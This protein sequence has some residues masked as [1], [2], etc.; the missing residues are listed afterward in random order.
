MDD[1]NKPTPILYYILYNSLD[2][3]DGRKRTAKQFCD[4]EQIRNKQGLKIIIGSRPK[5]ISA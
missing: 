5:S 2:F 4:K 1:E 3:L